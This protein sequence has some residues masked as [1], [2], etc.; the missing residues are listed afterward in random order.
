M[1]VK[2]TGNS[3]T[4][5]ALPKK[6]VQQK[7]VKPPPPPPPPSRTSPTQVS[8]GFDPP[9]ARPVDLGSTLSGTPLNAQRQV[10]QQNTTAAT[11]GTPASVTAT[12]GAAGSTTIPPATGVDP[13]FYAGPPPE[14]PEQAAEWLSDPNNAR[15]EGFNGTQL[16]S[17]DMAWLAA[18]GPE[19]LPEVFNA[20]GPEE[21][22]ELVADTVNGTFNDNSQFFP[23]DAA[24]RSSFNS[25]ATALGTM[26]AS[27]QTE[28]GTRLAREGN[29]EAS[30]LLRQGGP[31]LDAARRGYLDAA[32]EQAR[33]DPFMA[34]AAGNVLAGSQTL[35]NEYAQAW[36]DDF[37]SMLDKG[38]GD[39]PPH[40]RDSFHSGFASMQHD[41]LEQVV[42]MMANYNGPD[43]QLHKAQ[44]FGTAARTLDEQGNDNASLRAGLDQLFLSDSRG[45]VEWLSD[46][47]RPDEA[48]LPASGRRA[49]PAMDAKGEALSLYFRESVFENPDPNGAVVQQVNT[50]VGELKGELLGA[51]TQDER[52]RV[53]GFLGYLV[54][55]AALG[56]EG[57]YDANKDSQEARAALV[58][59]IFKPLEGKLTGAATAAGGPAAGLLAGEISKTG[60]EALIDFLN[61]GL[62]DD[63]NRMGELFDNVLTD[64]FSGVPVEHQSAVNA[65][66][67]RLLGLDDL[68]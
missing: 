18:N 48:G 25:I 28:V 58:N 37:L 62:K 53:G 52:N 32:R 55:T 7:E 12:G 47:T 23:N 35:V 4:S 14:S 24:L 17:Q 8:D 38:L 42:G 46:G 19:K 66:L 26:P 3:S 65:M 22:S 59:M 63:Q 27:F 6:E 56:Y 68:P 39:L 20:L 44:V 1:A 61:S 49:N 67:G 13:S 29:A 57:A 36:G 33:S 2:L 16:R 64:V 60:K 11:G 54:G 41:G 51:S 21:T 45:I 30:L 10:P 50:L 43:A 9:R 34:R 15:Y 5:A 31:G 40:S